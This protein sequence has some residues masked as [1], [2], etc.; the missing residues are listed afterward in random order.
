MDLLETIYKRRSIRNFVPGGVI[1]SDVVK[2]I[3][4]AGIR[5][6]SGKN[7]QP[8]NFAVIDN[9]KVI[10]K[11]SEYSRYKNTIS[12]SSCLILVYLDKNRSYDLKKDTLAIGACVENMLLTAC[13]YDIA[14][15]WNGDILS[16]A[17]SVNDILEISDS[18]ELMAMI[19]LG[20]EDTKITKYLKKTNRKN[21]D[22]TILNL[23][24]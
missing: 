4:D 24:C 13:N 8:W 3:I 22:S 6:P 18:Y 16:N 23:N 11:I 5:A 12:N 7:G 9:K 2:N 21:V 1:L 14:C 17:D 10:D 20:I 19:C 15:C